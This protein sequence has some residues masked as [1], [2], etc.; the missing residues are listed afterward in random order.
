[1]QRVEPGNRLFAPYWELLRRDIAASELV[2]DR[3]PEL[4][5]ED[6]ATAALVAFDFLLNIGL[7]LRQERV[8]AHW[9]MYTEQAGLFARQLAIPRTRAAAAEAVG[10]SIDDFDAQAPDALT[11]SFTYGHPFPGSLDAIVATVREG[12]RAN[13]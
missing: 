12:A 8:G 4:A 7:R 1:M 9:A 13:D 11:G 6:A 2:R 3:Y 5:S 10:L